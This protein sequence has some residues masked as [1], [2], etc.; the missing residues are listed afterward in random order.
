[1]SLKINGEG[2]PIC[3][4]CWRANRTTFVIYLQHAN[5]F[6]RIAGLQVNMLRCR[7]SA[8]NPKH[9]NLIQR[10]FDQH[11]GCGIVYT[12][13]PTGILRIR[14][15]HVQHMQWGCQWAMQTASW[16]HLAWISWQ[17]QTYTF[18]EMHKQKT[19]PWGLQQFQRMLL[20]NDK[21]VEATSIDNGRGWKNSAIHIKESC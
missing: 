20:E 3:W 17:T 11:P 13:T 4:A 5:S 12:I 18:K 6:G 8:R 10:H 1:M 16:M 21:P 7:L 15:K 14:I 2:C 19:E 9:H